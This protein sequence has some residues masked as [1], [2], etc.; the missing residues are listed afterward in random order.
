MTEWL[1]THTGMSVPV[2]PKLLQK[3]WLLT[4]QES[5]K[6]QKGELHLL[7]CSVSGF[8]IGSFKGPSTFTKWLFGGAHRGAW[9]SEVMWPTQCYMT[10]GSQNKNINQS[11]RDPKAHSTPSTQHSHRPL[12]HWATYKEWLKLVSKKFF[13]ISLQ[14]MSLTFQNTT[15]I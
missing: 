10:S 8:C 7:I 15:S 12:L 1:S 6:R 4:Q 2:N 9:D 14:E 3:W 13:S 5:W 11:A